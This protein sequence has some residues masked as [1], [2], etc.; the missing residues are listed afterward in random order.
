M[1]PLEVETKKI[2]GQH[3]NGIKTKFNKSSEVVNKF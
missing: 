3:S 2:N 1:H